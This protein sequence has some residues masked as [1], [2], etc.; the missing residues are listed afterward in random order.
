MKDAVLI[1]AFMFSITLIH[2]AHIIGKDP[3][4]T[5]R[6]LRRVTEDDPWTDAQLEPVVDYLLRSKLLDRHLLG[7]KPASS[8]G[9]AG[10][11]HDLSG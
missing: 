4:A 8:V 11:H 6:E 1:S 2:T 5:L 3:S 9:C 7:L 10:M